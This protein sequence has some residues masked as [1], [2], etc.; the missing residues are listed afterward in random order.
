[1][2][3]S[4]YIFSHR[5]MNDDIRSHTN[6]NDNLKFEIDHVTWHTICRPAAWN[7]LVRSETSW[8]DLEDWG[9]PGTN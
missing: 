8:D 5:I 6:T 7:D 9:R 2:L 3:V 1:M 4:D